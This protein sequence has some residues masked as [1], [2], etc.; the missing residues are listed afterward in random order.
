MN[1]HQQKDVQKLVAHLFRVEAGKMTSLL[2]RIFGLHQIEIAEDI[3]QESLI[4]ALNQWS[5]GEIPDNP[6]GWLLQVAKRKTINLLKREDRV[7]SSVGGDLDLDISSPHTVEEIFSEEAVTDSQLQMIFV[8]CHPGLPKESQIALTLKTLCGFSV[9]EIAHALL[10]TN[11]NINKRLYRAKQK[12]RQKQIELALPTTHQ[13][14]ERLDSVYL[15]L[16]LLFNEGYN[17]SHHEKLIREDL[18]LK[19]SDC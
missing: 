15:N 5:V 13:L 1:N 11:A 4:A 6:S 16:Y 12:F 17:S 2:T 3:V 9:P 8:C 14:D 18:C 10:T 19:P 7:R